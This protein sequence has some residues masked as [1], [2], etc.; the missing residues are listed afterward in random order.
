M[1]REKFL[2]VVFAVG[3]LI[4]IAFIANIVIARG[5][6]EY[7]VIIPPVGSTTTGRIRKENH[8]GA[9]N[10][11]TSVGSGN[12][13]TMYCAIRVANTGQDVTPNIRVD[14]GQRIGIPYYRV[15]QV[16]GHDTT[17]AVSTHPFVIVHVEA[18]GSWSPDSN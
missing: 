15:D 3:S 13:T 12:R 1:K 6:Q 11:N 8:T 18:H 4:G 17:L 9:V 2:R 16:V 5:I 10:N 14:S 7:H